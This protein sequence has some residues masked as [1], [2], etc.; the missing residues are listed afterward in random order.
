MSTRPR[1]HH[2]PGVCLALAAIALCWPIASSAAEGGLQIVPSGFAENW[3]QHG[4][5]ALFRMT[6]FWMLVGLF[7]VLAVVL[8]RYAFK[9][10]LE[11]IEERDRRIGGAR[12]R[13]SELSDQA[14]SLLARHAEAL[15]EARARAQSER[16]TV[17]EQARATAQTRVEAARG[18][19]SEQT[20]AARQEVDT[21]LVSARASLQ[22][23]ADQIAQTIAE[24]LLGSPAS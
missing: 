7:A 10:L 22:V 8:N 15:G 13:A 23:E 6:N 4:F 19:A 17:L 2:Q 16:Q 5:L 9:P 3:A 20:L 21:A 12:E 14:G 11:V 24:R 18:E 1:F